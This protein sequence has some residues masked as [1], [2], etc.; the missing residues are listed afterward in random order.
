[1][2]ADSICIELN[3]HIQNYHLTGIVHSVFDNAFNVLT[4][5]NKFITFLNYSKPMAPNAIRL[6]RNI[7]FLDFNIEPNMKLYFYKDFIWL[8]DL[9]ITFIIDKASKWDS[10]P[11]FTYSKEKEN[12]LQRKISFIEEFLI[13]EGKKDGILPLLLFLNEKHKDFG[14]KDFLFIKDRFLDFVD[15]YLHY[16]KLRISDKVKKIIGFG[17]GLTP[18]MDDFISGLMVSR[19]YIY[20]YLNMNLNECIEFNY[21]MIG[22]IDGKTTRVSEEMLKYSSKGKVNEN[23]RNLMISLFS[24]SSFEGLMENLKAVA[25]FGETSGTDIIS[26]IYFG[27]KILYKQYTRRLIDS[28]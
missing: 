6:S 25:S 28:E 15:S 13:N 19:I 9:N 5:D 2:I 17:A 1:M 11:V 16:S 14:N 20:D 24:D 26:G 8:R 12:K 4:S 18:A 23:I 10:C 3:E 21:L 7:S 22:E 27:S